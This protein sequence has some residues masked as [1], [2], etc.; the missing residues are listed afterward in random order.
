MATASS[1]N[2]RALESLIH[3]GALDC[4]EPK[5]NRAQLMA[6][7]DL[8]LDWAN[9]RARD[10]VSGQGSLLDLLTVDSSAGTNTAVSTAPKAASVADYAPT[11]KLR[12][13]K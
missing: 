11:E 5:A 2:R 8:L 7:L 10:R 4:L 12:L 1:L 6:D 9:S 13:E 3:C